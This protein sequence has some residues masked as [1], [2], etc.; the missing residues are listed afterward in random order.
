MGSYEII[1]LNDRL[2]FMSAVNKNKKRSE[3]IKQALEDRRKG[4][5][6]GSSEQQAIKSK[7]A[8]LKG[9]FQTL[10]VRWTFRTVRCRLHTKFMPA[11]ARLICCCLDDL[12]IAEAKD[13]FEGADGHRVQDS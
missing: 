5:S 6:A 11:M 9:Q 4:R 3:E 10:L 12:S 13:G 8:E 2:H 7:L 1:L